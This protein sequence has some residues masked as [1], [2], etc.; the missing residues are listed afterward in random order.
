MHQE[1][2]FKIIF[3]LW[4]RYREYGN[5]ISYSRLEQ[6]TA[7]LGAQDYKIEEDGVLPGSIEDVETCD[8][9]SWH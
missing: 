1:E 4:K 9:V 6:S 5:S 3:I 7:N 8:H 2:D